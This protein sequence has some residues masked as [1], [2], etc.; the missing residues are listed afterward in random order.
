M[1]RIRFHP[2]ALI[3]PLGIAAWFCIGMGAAFILSLINGGA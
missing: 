2:R 1:T 3:I